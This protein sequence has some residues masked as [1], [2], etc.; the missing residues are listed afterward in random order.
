MINPGI[1]SVSRSSKSIHVTWSTDFSPAVLC[2]FGN[3]RFIHT[4]TANTSKIM[5]GPNSI[6]DWHWTKEVSPHSLHIQTKTTTVCDVL[7]LD[8]L[9]LLHHDTL[10]AHAA[11]LLEAAWAVPTGRAAAKELAV[12]SKAG[13][14]GAIWSVVY[15]SSALNVNTHFINGHWCEALGVLGSHG[16]CHDGRGR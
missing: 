9:D 4:S 6:L 14:A 8:R 15:A 11:G 5:S 13:L 10:G 7:Q 3:C 2:D 12:L 16:C 1:F